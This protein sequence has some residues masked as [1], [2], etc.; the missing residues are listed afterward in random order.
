MTRKPKK[1]ESRLIL[2]SIE[3]IGILFLLVGLLH[4]SFSLVEPVKSIS[5]TSEKLNYNEKEPGSFKVEKSAKWIE[6]GKARIT[7]DVD[8][9]LKTK[10]KNVDVIFVLDNSDSMRGNKLQR[11]KEDSIELI[12]SLLANSNNKVAIISFNTDSTILSDFTNDRDSLLNI[13]NNLNN[14]GA[15]NYYR[16][17]VNVDNLLRN[18][19]QKQDKNCIVLFLTDGY[20]CVEIP[21]EETEYKMLK[22]QYPYLIINGIQ[23]EMSSEILDPIKKVSDNQYLADMGTLNNVLFDA[24]IDPIRYEKFIITDYIDTDNFM[25]ESI[26]DIKVSQGKVD[27][28]EGEQKVT[29]TIELLRSGISPSM[30]IDV[31]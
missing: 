8:T 16:A 14:A 13:I 31:V 20:P 1:V 7:F 11:V 9:V 26:D 10:N 29:W 18:Y 17:L 28:N 25:V 6:K 21:N 15:T 5:F 23:Y 30:T 2:A 12:D 22:R 4:S 3:I 19:V 27:F 24:S